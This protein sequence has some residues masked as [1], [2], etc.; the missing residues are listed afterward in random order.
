MAALQIAP[1]LGPGQTGCMQTSEL[2]EKVLLDPYLF[3]SLR[4]RDKG[5]QWGHANKLYMVL[6]AIQNGQSECQ[7]KYV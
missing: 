3:W 2:Y 1:G 5:R 6:K 4:G 7:M